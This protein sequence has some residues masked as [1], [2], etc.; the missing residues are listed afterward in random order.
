MKEIE[1]DAD[2]TCWDEMWQHWTVTF[3]SFSFNTFQ[4]QRDLIWIHRSSL[5]PLS[6]YPLFIFKV[7]NLSPSKLDNSPPQHY[8]INTWLLSPNCLLSP[9]ASSIKSQSSLQH[10]SPT[11]RVRRSVASQPFSVITSSTTE[12][13]VF[14]L[15]NN[16]TPVP[17]VWRREVWHRQ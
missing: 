10:L 5:V 8:Y 17:P 3:I 16:V 2:K 1:P 12:S 15:G 9:S 4:T 14:F 6:L 13:Y 7:P 11:E